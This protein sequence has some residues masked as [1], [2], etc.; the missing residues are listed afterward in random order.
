[1]N[2]FQRARD[3]A[4]SVRALLLGNTANDAIPAEK[5]LATIEE[6]LNLGIDLIAPNSPELG[7]GDACLCREERYIYVRNDISTEEYAEL[8]AHELGHWE[9]DADKTATS[10]ASLAAMGKLGGSPGVVYVEAYGARER[11]ELQ[12]NVFARELL[13]PRRIVRSLFISGHGARKIAKELGI[14]LRIVRQQMLDAVLLPDA[15]P[16]SQKGLHDPSPDQEEAAKAEE[17]FV[18]VVAGPGTGKTSTLIHRVKYLIEEQG[19]DP[20]HI[21]VLTFTNK[22]AF[23][24]VERLRAAGI[25]RA[26]DVWAGTFHA[27]GL[28]FLRKYHDAFGLDNDIVVADKLNAVTMLNHEL[29]HLS[30]SYYLRVE[31][32]YEWLGKAIKAIQRL[33]EEL[34]DPAEY[35]ARLA[36]LQCDSAELR[37]EREDIATLYEAYERVL[38]QAKVVDFV[39]L[40]ALPAKSIA[41][42]RARYSELADKFQY[43]LV[44]EYQDV[45]TAM[46]HLI[47]QLAHKGKSLWVVGDVRQAIH[48]WRGA[49]VRSLIVFEQTFRDQA[50]ST[51][52]K[53]KKY[54]LKFNRRSTQKIVDFVNHCGIVHVLQAKLPLD[55]TESQQGAGEKQ[56]TLISCTP[57]AAITVAV[58][59]A[60]GEACVRGIEHVQQSVLC[61]KTV[62]VEHMAEQ[63]R[64]AGIPVLYIGELSHRTEVKR[65]LC[66]MQLL[67]ERQPRTLIGLGHADGF[68]IPL[69]DINLILD[70][71]T[72]D[73]KLQRGRWLGKAIPGLSL[74][75]QAQSALE[76]LARLLH[77]HSRYST[78]WDF[79]C[80]ILLEHRYGLSSLE[81]KSIEGHLARI[82]LWQFTNAVHTGVGDG[83]KPSIP[84]YLL[85]LQLRQKINDTH[86][87]RELPPEALALNAVRIQTVHGSK[88]L[89]YDAVH[90]AYIENDCYGFEKKSDWKPDEDITD[91]VP[92]EVLGSSAKDF[93]F[94]QSVE[95]NNLF[96]V[97]ISR[98]KKELFLYEDANFSNKNRPPQL[99]PIAS[100]PVVLKQFA[101]GN[102]PQT[103]PTQKW[104]PTSKYQLTFDEFE[105]YARCSLQ[106]WYRF[107][108]GL[109][110]EQEVDAS[111]RARFAIMETLRKVASGLVSAEIDALIDSWRDQNLPSVGEDPALWKD[112]TFVLSRGLKWLHDTGGVYD[113]PDTPLGD[114]R[115]KLPWLIRTNPSKL[116]LVRFSNRGTSSLK[117]LIQP[118][119]NGLS[120]TLE[121]S[122]L[123]TPFIATANPSGNIT[124]TNAIKAAERFAAGDRSPIKGTHCNFCVY[125]TI[126]PA[127]PEKELVA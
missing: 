7:S 117:T 15:L 97:G 119:L 55:E 25:N 10:V 61:R 14:P 57:K 47:K 9:L 80:D 120:A 52:S 2:P 100:A 102:F 63:L 83:K 84:R 78:P 98:A 106:Y 30:L 11:Q 125:Q 1:M 44:D 33:K 67:T 64:Q 112:A 13:L 127:L 113:E 37:A 29:K 85:R 19:V 70:R 82:A 23:E 86:I 20:S 122:N 31:D 56:P 69:E 54:P 110:R 17:R 123:L 58:T 96:Y 6:K 66:L 121:I 48:H 90:L 62:D 46:V 111:I 60:I 38:R 35:R 59:K 5:L 76:K 36:T 22:A 116:N 71:S 107:K 42:D 12:A 72:S 88:G 3:E 51:H 109:K 77:G 43:V 108:L 49:S 94:E 74:S 124:A 101:S 18:N 95:R 50:N 16:E 26:A 93:A 32:P 115:I 28:E 45:T 24:L 89:E 114:L 40:V 21:L 126:C 27:F 34:V 4:N 87:D 91:L 79:V 92:P 41:S 105:V 68:E 75:A 118:M 8:V 73:I 65:I 81:D 39:D 103:N 53:I 99:V 104:T